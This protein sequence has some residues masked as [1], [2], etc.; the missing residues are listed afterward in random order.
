MSRWLGGYNNAMK[1]A[2]A[3][4]YDEGGAS[5]RTGSTVVRAFVP[6]GQPKKKRTEVV[7]DPELALYYKSYEAVRIVTYAAVRQDFALPDVPTTAARPWP[8]RR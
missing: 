7:I 2:K 5:Q 8:T 6:R 4:S 1:S 3:T